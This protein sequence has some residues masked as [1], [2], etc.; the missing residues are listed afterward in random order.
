M[1]G[2]M[3]LISLNKPHPSPRIDLLRGFAPL[4]N[5][6]RD[7]PYQRRVRP[8]HF[9]YLRALLCI[10]QSIREP[11][12]AVLKVRLQNGLFFHRRSQLESLQKGQHIVKLPA[13]YP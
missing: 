9:A 1:M 2:L 5:P 12:Q 7:P 3:R 10:A 8:Q 11:F 4:F 13:H 6:F